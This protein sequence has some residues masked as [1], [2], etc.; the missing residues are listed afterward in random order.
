VSQPSRIPGFLHT[1]LATLGKCALALVVFTAIFGGWQWVMA[2][3][4]LPGASDR[5]GAC[6][7]WFVGSSTM[8]RWGSLQADM[9]PWI[10]QNRGIGGAT[11]QEINLHIAHDKASRAPQAIVYY[12][13]ENDLAFGHSVDQALA[14]LREFLAIKTRLFGQTPVFLIS[15]KPSP[16]RWDRRADQAQ[17]NVVAKQIADARPDAFYID[18]VPLLMEHGEPGPFYMEDGLHMNDQ[19]YRRWTQATQRALGS[20][21]PR[22]VLQKCNPGA[23]PRP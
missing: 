21:L 13:G 18:I 5:E 3:Q 6:V 19:G 8:S 23:L 17:Y 15:L 7:I 14:D 1:A 10:A 22:S 9:R 12:A 4:P 2:R 11:M 20:D 16:T